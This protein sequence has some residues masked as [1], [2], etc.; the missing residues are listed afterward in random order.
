MVKSNQGKNSATPP[1]AG[2]S[3]A[4]QP[5][6]G[7]VVQ[8]GTGPGRRSVAMETGRPRRWVA[9]ETA[10]PRR[11]VAM[12]TARSTGPTRCSRAP[13]EAAPPDRPSWNESSA[14][15]PGRS[16]IKGLVYSVNSFVIC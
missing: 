9:T 6:A 1:V 12:D 10:R 16:T 8:P 15:N 13:S 7:T 3:T 2:C 4:A 5:A 14:S 11:P